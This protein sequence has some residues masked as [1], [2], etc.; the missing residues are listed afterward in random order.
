MY[1]ALLWSANGALAS[2]RSEA[3][4]EFD[5]ARKRYENKDYAEAKKDFEELSANWISPQLF[6]NAGG[7]SYR[8]GDDGAAALWFRRALVLDSTLTEARQNL[9]YLRHRQ[10]FLQS[11]RGP[12]DG[13]TS[14]LRRPAWR[15][16]LILSAG[17]LGVFS[18][19]LASLRLPRGTRAALIW[20]IVLS[21]L[22]AVATAVGYAGK[23]SSR[24]LTTAHIVTG[25]KVRALTAPVDSSGMV[26][27]LPPGSEIS[28]LKERGP[29]IYA[30][31]PGGSRGWV[32]AADVDPLWPYDIRLAE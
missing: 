15:N 9:R 17:S 23:K 3:E 27:A 16:L 31:I 24:N 10:G 13:Y 21:A 5:D 20:S 6:Y 11:E 4:A 25:A 14:I 28:L 12:L 29:W 2:G 19:A 18:L 22:L 7:A 32:R 1:V 8:A 30:E 26:V